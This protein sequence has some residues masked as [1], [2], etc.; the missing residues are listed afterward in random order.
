MPV[1]YFCTRLAAVA[2][3]DHRVE[4]APE[5]RV[6]EDR[7]AQRQEVR[8]HVHE[9][10]V[11]ERGGRQPGPLDLLERHRLG[12]RRLGLEAPGGQLQ[13]PE[14]GRSRVHP[15]EDL[16]QRPE[17]PARVVGQQHLVVRRERLPPDQLAGEDAPRAEVVGAVPAHPGPRDVRREPVELPRPEGAVEADEHVGVPR[18][19]GDVRHHG[20]VDEPVGVVPREEAGPARPVGQRVRRPPGPAGERQQSAVPAVEQVVHE[21][22]GRRLGLVGRV[23]VLR[24]VPPHVEVEARVAQRAP[25]P[26]AEVVDR[27]RSALGLGR[28]VREVAR[29]VDRARQAHDG[30]LAA[31]ALP[32]GHG[33]GVRQVERVQR[34]RRARGA[35]APRPRR[36]SRPRPATR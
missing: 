21:R 17:Q 9:L 18:Q 33:P 8:A 4:P 24:P 14:V 7:A 11:A 30:D 6:L 32:D 28:V 22:V 29:L 27:L 23:E 36:R 20:V 19:L 3:G 16:V 26:P 5:A 31:A 10:G 12:L 15:R 34:P 25:A 13:P 2:L 1:S 35:A